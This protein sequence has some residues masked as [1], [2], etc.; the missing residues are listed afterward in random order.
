MSLQLMK[1]GAF[2]L[3]CASAAS[4]AKIYTID[5]TYEGE[6]FFNK[7]NFFTGLDPTRGYVQYQSQADAASTK[8]GSK[9]VNTINGQNFMGVDHTNTY[10][11]FG[12]GRPSVRIETKKTYNHGLFILDLAHMPS[13]T[14]G[15]WPAFWT[16]SDVNYPAQGEID[17]LEN[18]HENTQSLNVLHTSAGFSV[19]GNKKGLQQS[20]DQTT[21]NCDDNAQSSDYGSQFTGQG[22]ASTNINPGSYGSALN[23]VGGGVYAM[24]WTSDVIRVWSFPK[25]VI[26]LDIIAGKPDPSKWGLPTFTTA[27]GK[28]DID[29]HFK[30]HKVV[31]DTTFC[32]NWA[33]QDFF[34]KQTSCYDP[35]LYPTCSE[36]V[37][38]NPSKYADTY[39]L[40]NSLKV[41]QLNEAPV[42]TSSSSTS[43]S[44][45][46]KPTTSS[47]VSTTSSS[48]ASSSASLTSSSSSL[49][50]SATTAASTSSTS[51]SSSASST[52]SSS[53]SSSV[54]ATSATSSVSSSTSADPTSSTSTSSSVSS[55][56]SADPTSST[57]VSSSVSSSTDSSSTTG[58]TSST[59]SS[60]SSTT[61][62]SSTS[63]TSTSTSVSSSATSD[64]T[65]STSETSSSTRNSRPNSDFHNNQQRIDLFH[66]IFLIKILRKQLYH[67]DHHPILNHRDPNTRANNHPNDNLNS[68]HNL[69]QHHHQAPPFLPQLRPSHATA[70]PAP[71]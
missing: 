41:F 60:A 62:D 2:A 16:Y 37:G 53:T 17:I 68:L 29:S 56:T 21:Y 20:G 26:P 11:P 59:S 15:N 18:I 67:R 50:S 23:A 22:C 46:S 63:E 32:G 44:T 49:S 55:S 34:W 27:Q 7:F 12:A 39:W 9:L 3:A 14:C 6:G 47:T 40:I 45:S 31:L 38:K 13:S 33:G 8:F 42:T 64:S 5:E 61:S 35:I 25:V 58:S 4:A 57:S 71:P 66:H 65:T 19:A 52:A 28:G 30:D 69:P 1:V 43:S 51:T 48:S 10:D 24:E 36:Y 70:Q 54:S